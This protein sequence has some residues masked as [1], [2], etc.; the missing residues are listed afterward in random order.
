METAPDAGR[1]VFPGHME[2]Q[3]ARRLLAEAYAKVNAGKV[4][5]RTT[6]RARAAGHDPPHDIAYVAEPDVV[7]YEDGLGVSLGTD[8]LLY[9]EFPG[10]DACLGIFE[11]EVGGA[12]MKH[13]QKRV[14]GW[15][16]RHRPPKA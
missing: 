14:R 12:L 10:M 15:L 6:K 5:R 1:F 4:V 9:D 11:E 3:T 2:R 8:L 7:E 13:L 16:R